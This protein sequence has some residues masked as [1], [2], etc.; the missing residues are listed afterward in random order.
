[1][2]IYVRAMRRLDQIAT[3]L[4]AFATI[5]AVVD[6]VRAEDRLPGV[7]EDHRTVKP[8]PEPIDENQENRDAIKVG[9]WD[10]RVSGSVTIDIGTGNLPP[11]RR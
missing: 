4:G 8:L 10:V 2:S 5:C 3:I 11:P 9:D 1:M 7:S 6:P